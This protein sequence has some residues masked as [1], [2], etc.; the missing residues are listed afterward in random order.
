MTEE[1]QLAEE[2]AWVYQAYAAIPATEPEVLN[3]AL[4]AAMATVSSP[5][6]THAG[7]AVTN[8]R[9]QGRRMPWM[10]LS[11]WI[12]LGA[13]CCAVIV[14]GKQW[15]QTIADRNPIDTALQRDL[16][17]EQLRQARTVVQVRPQV[18]ARPRHHRMA[19]RP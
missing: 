14:L 16:L 8:V 18:R 12:A 10:R 5:T 19:R 4:A 7:A 17:S 13:V 2:Y 1:E 3:R 15:R 9:Q 11:P 6:N